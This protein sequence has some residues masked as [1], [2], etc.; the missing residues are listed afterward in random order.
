[1]KGLASHHLQKS[2]TTCGV[3]FFGQEQ[4]LE[5][6]ES[7]CTQREALMHLRSRARED[8]QSRYDMKDFRQMTS[9]YRNRID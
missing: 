7:A 8:I 6:V 2:C 3:D 5:A 4:L 9:A 1:M